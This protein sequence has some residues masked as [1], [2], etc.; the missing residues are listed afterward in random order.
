LTAD[1]FVAAIESAARSLYGE[2]ARHSDAERVV[3][4]LVALAG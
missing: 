1:V 3:F 2:L 4:E